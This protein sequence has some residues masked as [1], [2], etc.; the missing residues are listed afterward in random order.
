MASNSQS[1]AKKKKTHRDLFLN[2]VN[3]FLADNAIKSFQ[4]LKAKIG[5]PPDLK[6]K[7]ICCLVFEPFIFSASTVL[8]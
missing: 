6:T 3:D 4:I 7:R 1:F 5:K 8:Y 2:I